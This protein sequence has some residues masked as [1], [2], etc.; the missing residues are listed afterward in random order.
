[1]LGN[2][3]QLPAPIVHNKRNVNVAEESHTLRARAR[4]G[5]RRGQ[6]GTRRGQVGTRPRTSTASL[7][8]RMAL[9][10][11]RASFFL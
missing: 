2:F 3:N 6:V 1:M 11:F 4:V 10:S 5:T 8:G 9:E 7:G